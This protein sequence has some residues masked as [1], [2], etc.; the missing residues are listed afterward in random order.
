MHFFCPSCWKEVRE[1]VIVCPAC[2]VDIAAYESRHD[3]A[4]KLIS[5]TEHF[6]QET[7]IRAVWILGQR[8]EKKSVSKLIELVRQGSDP[9]LTVTALEAIYNI[10]GSECLDILKEASHSL[11]PIV[12]NKAKTLLDILED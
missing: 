7:R 11:Y 3:F 9:F 12:S 8:K 6:E 5:A 1:E 10:E 2:G 4:D